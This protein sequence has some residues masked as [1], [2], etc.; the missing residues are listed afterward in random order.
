MTEVAAPQIVVDSNLWIAKGLSRFWPRGYQNLLD[1]Y[2]EHCY[3]DR[4]YSEVLSAYS[5]NAHYLEAKETTES[6]LS[7][8]TEISA[9][10]EWWRIAESLSQRLDVV[11]FS[12]ALMPKIWKDRE[13]AAKTISLNLPLAADDKH[14]RVIEF[15]APADLELVTL[16]PSLTADQSGTMEKSLAQAGI[17]RHE[18]LLA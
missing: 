13:I 8:G 16:R 7:T 4:I 3:F 2:S 5:K 14:F 11:H 17:D 12:D 6:V 10:R 15:V 9:E 1:G 18:P